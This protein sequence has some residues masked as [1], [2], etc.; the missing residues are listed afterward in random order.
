MRVSLKWPKD[1]KFLASNIFKLSTFLRLKTIDCKI[2]KHQNMVYGD[3]RT[4]EPSLVHQF[5]RSLYLLDHNQRLKKN[6]G[7]MRRILYKLLSVTRL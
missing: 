5:V 4:N 3:Y 1:V 7:A 2:S 6:H